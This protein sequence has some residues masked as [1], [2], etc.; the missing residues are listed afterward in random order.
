VTSGARPAIETLVLAAVLLAGLDVF[1]IQGIVMPT[2]VASGSMA[3]GLMGP[4]RRW[5]CGACARTF[6]CSDESLP[7]EGRAA[8]C[9]NCGACAADEGVDRSGAR[10]LVD[11]S[12]FAW[13]GPRRF[14][15]VVFR[16]P[17]DARS[18]CVKRVAGLPGETVGIKDGDLF[19]DGRIVVKDGSEFDQVAVC[20]YET[21]PG[22]RRWRFEAGS[23]WSAGNAG[24]LYCHRSTD[25]DASIDWLTYHH[26]R[27]YGSADGTEATIGDESPVD[28]NESRVPIAVSDIAVVCDVQAAGGGE[29]HLRAGS[30]GNEFVARLDTATGAGTLA[31]HNGRSVSFRSNPDALRTYSRLMLALV[32][33][34]AR[35]TLDGRMLAKC[36]YEPGADRISRQTLAIGARGGEVAVRR[37]QVLRD[38]HYACVAAGPSK[39]HLGEDEYFLLGDNSQHALDGR[40]WGG[41]PRAMIVGRALSW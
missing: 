12:A 1:V 26:E 21:P 24:E 40:S 14:E 25:V 31:H 19:V 37:L 27:T 3:P 41:V 2:V 15:R 17:N 32:D 39:Y 28:Q 20:V 6:V 23:N 4:H 13:R 9:P 33:R 30:N 29:V 16:L 18:L 11:R 8:V 36:D 7:G 35:L 10:V 22:D 38:V 5:E 34:R